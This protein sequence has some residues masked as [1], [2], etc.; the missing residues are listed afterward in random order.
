[1]TMG[2]NEQNNNNNKFS[3]ENNMRLVQQ[4]FGK[5]AYEI[6]CFSG[7]FTEYFS[8]V[9]LTAVKVI[10]FFISLSHH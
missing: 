7:I 10:Y 9:R 4:T 1:M 6:P 3:I 8:S 5:K 2:W